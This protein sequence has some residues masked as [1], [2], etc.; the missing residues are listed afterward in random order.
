MLVDRAVGRFFGTTMNVVF[1][2]AAE[3]GSTMVVE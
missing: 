2:I 1:P 3:N